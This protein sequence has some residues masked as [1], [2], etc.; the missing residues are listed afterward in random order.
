[1][2]REEFIQEIKNLKFIKQHTASIE[3]EKYKCSENKIDVII[4]KTEDKLL[5]MKF[6]LSIKTT[7]YDQALVLLNFITTN[8]V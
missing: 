7:N 8:R 4:H 6:G 5:M 3:L 1:M 2:N